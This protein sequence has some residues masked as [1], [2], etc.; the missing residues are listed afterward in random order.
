MRATGQDSIRDSTHGAVARRA[1]AELLVI[2]LEDRKTMDQAMLEAPSFLRLEGRDRAFARA[3]AS[4]ALRYLGPIDAALAS[5]LSRPLPDNGEGAQNLLRIG[6]AQIAIL[7]TPIHAA[8]GATVEAAKSWRQTFPFAGLINAVLRRLSRESVA[9]IQNPDPELIL[10]GWLMARW[11]GIYGVQS[12]QILALEGLQEAPLDLTL[13]D[14]QSAA[15]WAEALGAILR[16]SGSLRLTAH[17]GAV[18]ELPGFAQG[19]YWVQDEAA[20]LPARLL[21]AQRDARVLDACGAPGGKSLQ[22]AAMGV[23]LTVLDQTRAKLDRVKEN[24]A[25]VGLSADLTLADARRFTSYA[26]FD[27]ILVDAPCL[28]TGTLRRHPEAA[29]IK[30]VVTL[31]QLVAY[32]RQILDNCLRQLAP[33]GTLVYSVCSREPEEGREQIAW[34]LARDFG[35][36]CRIG[37]DPVSMHEVPGFEHFVTPEGYV[38]TNQRNPFRADGLAATDPGD[39]FFVARLRRS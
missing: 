11:R 30:D 2:V 21:R 15:Y 16:P 8:V 17:S 9:P 33:G 22:L 29:W 26:P 39:G 27:A 5:L 37:L 13:K 6:A 24:F 14:P 1:A 4:T 7:G 3:M 25:R 34:V 23:R 36:E 28:A 18:T 35:G 31:E 32:Q 38:D 20:S 10:P 12:A 19:A